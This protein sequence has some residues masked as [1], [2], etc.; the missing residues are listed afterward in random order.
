MVVKKKHTKR[1]K[2]E[3]EGTEINNTKPVKEV[4]F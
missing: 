3:E 4:I 1:G 2:R